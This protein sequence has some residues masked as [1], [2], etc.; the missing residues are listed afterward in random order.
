MKRKKM[1][2]KKME[3]KMKMKKMGWV[4]LAS[5][6]VEELHFQPGVFLKQARQPSVALS[7]G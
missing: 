3:M 4:S 1:K 6:V 5:L 7:G 2:R